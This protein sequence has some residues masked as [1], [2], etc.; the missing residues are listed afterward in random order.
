MAVYKWKTI[1][2][3]TGVYKASFADNFFWKLQNSI[4]VH[5]LRKHVFFNLTFFWLVVTMCVTNQFGQVI[6]FLT[7]GWFILT[8]CESRLQIYRNDSE[9][10]HNSNSGY[11]V[12]LNSPRRCSFWVISKTHRFY[13]YIEE[14]NKKLGAFRICDNCN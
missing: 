3:E 8:D 4:N 14:N 13:H 6:F 7:G 12:I 11:S 1:G 9:Y 5:F 10:T 2:C